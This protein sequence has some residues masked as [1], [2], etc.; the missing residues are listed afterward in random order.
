MRAINWLILTVHVLLLL[1]YIFQN[2]IIYHC[3]G[4]GS[5]SLP[6]SAYGLP[7]AEEVPI[8]NGRLITFERPGTERVIYYFHG[9]G[10]RVA[11]DYW[12]IGQLYAICN[13][14]VKAVEYPDCLNPGWF[15]HSEAENIAFAE[16]VLLTTLERAKKNYLLGASLGTAYVMAIY[17]NSWCGIINGVILENPFTSV[18]DVI[19]HVPQWLLFNHWNNSARISWMNRGVP[20]LFL[21]SGSDE[22]VPPHMST[23]LFEAWDAQPKGLKTQVILP[24]ALHGHAASHPAYLPAI[25]KFLR[26]N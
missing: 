7:A 20:V 16:E 11:S 2:R 4:N 21:T 14:S 25:A 18:V 8:L 5:A 17:P 13:C 1:L 22:I 26:L 19:Q 12:R 10:L 15:G 24:G 23:T 6:T 9:N 3:G